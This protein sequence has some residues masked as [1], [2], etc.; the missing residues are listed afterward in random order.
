MA[1]FDAKNFNGEVFGAYVGQI[2]N[3]NRNE[4]LKS[5]ALV[6]KQEYAT[7]LPDQAGGNYI[8]VPI[9]A[10][11]SG[12]PSNYDGKT[13]IG[14]ESRKTYTHGRVVIGRSQGWTE[15]DF[16]TDVTGEDFLPAAQEV[17]E[18]WDDVDQNTILATMKGVFAMTGAK[19][20]EFVNAHT[21][22]ISENDTD[23]KFGETTLNTAIQ[24]A[25]GD[26]K[27][28]F[29]IAIMHSQV[30]T[31]LENLKIL[32]YAK[33]TDSEGIQRDVTLGTINGRIVLIDDNMPVEVVEETSDG[34]G[35]GYV[36]YTT[37]VFGAGAIEY[38]NC[39]VKKP[40][41]MSEDDKTNGGETT[42]W[43]RQRKVFAPYGISFKKPS[44][45]SPTDAQLED[46]KNWELANSNESGSPEYFPHKAIPI[47]RIITRG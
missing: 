40:F 1:L 6:E 38:T 11:I 32:A 35:D 3:L 13:D 14:T 24:K 15:K 28:K 37:Y 45:I 12:K 47:A 17:A 10:R 39:G 20:L 5:G 42:L 26:N 34:A 43:S 4:L 8:V 18:F 29:S 19:N 44:F 2:D 25:L 16:S 33:Y 27:A 30:S 9:K 7:M 41:S 36:K 21:Y 22:D 46:G 23:N 31:N